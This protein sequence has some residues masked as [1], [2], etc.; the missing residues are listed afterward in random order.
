MDSPSSKQSNEH[1]ERSIEMENSEN[2]TE[3]TL[4]QS[5]A[6]FDFSIPLVEKTKGT[7]R[8]FYNNCNGLEINNLI[9]DVIGRKRDK[10]VNQY[11]GE[12]ENPTK[13]DRLLRQAMAWEVDMVMLAETCTDWNKMAA[14]R[15][16]RHVTQTYDPR[17]CWVG[18]TS[19]VDVGNHLKPGGAGTYATGRC[20]G[21]ILDKG[22]DPWMMGRWTYTLIGRDVNEKT[23]LFI[24]GYRTG[25]RTG[26]AGINTT[27]S[28]QAAILAKQE[29]ERSHH[30]NHSSKICNGG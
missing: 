26:K 16:V 22:N 2:F 18:S 3:G 13:L 24:T 30:M 15:A 28:Q 19:Q 8:L 5:L 14:R 7:L 1:E 6:L 27:W 17:G 11:I 29:R 25:N 10:Q 9:E 23:I 4:L 20:N 21:R 12:I